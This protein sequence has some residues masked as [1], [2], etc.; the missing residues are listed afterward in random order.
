MCIVDRDYTCVIVDDEPHVI[1][2][3][4][5][6]VPWADHHFNHIET[7]E[8][9]IAALE[10][11]RC[12]PVDLLITDVRMPELDGLSLINE[13]K[14]VNAEIFVL[15]MSGYRDFEYVKKAMFYGA[16]GYLV[17]PVFEEDVVPFFAEA[18]AYIQK[19]KEE[20][21][22]QYNCKR[23]K[24][25]L[26][27]N[28]ATDDTMDKDI[29]K[30]YVVNDYEVLKGENRLHFVIGWKAY[31][32]M[33]TRNSI[34]AL[35]ESEVR[36]PF[37]SPFD[38]LELYR[39]IHGF[40]FL[41]DLNYDILTGFF[42]EQHRCEYWRIV[43][44]GPTLSEA[45]E[46]Y[47]GLLDK[48]NRLHHFSESDVQLH[49]S[50]HTTIKEFVDAIVRVDK[51]SLT[52]LIKTLFCDVKSVDKNLAELASEIKHLYEKIVESIMLPLE[53]N[54]K[55]QVCP[56]AVFTLESFELEELLIRFENYLKAVMRIMENIRNQ[57]K[58]GFKVRIEAFVDANYMHSITIKEL[59]DAMH[60]HPSYMGQKL[61]QLFGESFNHY[62]HRVRIEKSIL[63]MQQ[64]EQR[65]FQQIAYEVG[66]NHY[67]AFLKAFKR[68]KGMTPM[69]FVKTNRSI[70]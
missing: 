62:V 7:F 26:L 23:E 39:S 70:R 3:L 64:D 5:S 50:A 13:A 22:C 61:I 59:A 10:F 31:E 15:V 55:H 41:T 54:E 68:S 17:K 20:L 38:M 42:E 58:D 2:G 29:S 48:L 8:N 46:Q 47:R 24:I 51:E 18:K 21:Y 40:I 63:L 35:K 33:H 30:N 34:E 25:S 19:K 44:A 32:P 65:D 27:F 57:H 36:I 37:T 52:E 28:V 69:D 66:Y 6:M 49:K 67:P 14:K 53:E 56:Y 43:E 16:N 1:E 45:K 9:A 12:N 11:L 4:V 60:M